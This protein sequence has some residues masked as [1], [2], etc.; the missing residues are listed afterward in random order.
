MSRVIFLSR[1]RMT[2]IL[3]DR[4]PVNTP[5]SNHSGSQVW[6]T[7][8]PMV[9]LYSALPEGWG[10]ENG[11]KDGREKWDVRSRESK[12]LSLVDLT[13]ASAEPGGQRTWWPNTKTLRVLHMLI[14][15]A[16]LGQ[17]IAQQALPAIF[18]FLFSLSCLW[19]TF[20]SFFF[21]PYSS[22]W[23]KCTGALNE[24]LQLSIFILSNG[25]RAQIFLVPI[26]GEDIHLGFP[27]N[28]FNVREKY[29][30]TGEFEYWNKTKKKTKIIKGLTKLSSRTP[31]LQESNKPP[32]IHWEPC[33]TFQSILLGWAKGFLVYFLLVYLHFSTNLHLYPYSSAL[34]FLLSFQF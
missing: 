4:H 14:S 34:P 31:I 19:I 25:W 17:C 28:D 29:L 16:L 12:R 30:K 20:F 5:R 11:K 3:P 33:S 32:F 26:V 8:E 7:L 13:P 21:L 24:D 18:W 2:I 6:K 27:Q 1:L 9:R 22:H 23:H 15:S 10:K